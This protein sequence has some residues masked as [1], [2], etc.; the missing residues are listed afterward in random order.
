[1][2]QTASYVNSLSQSVLI[3][4]SIIITGTINAASFTGSL[5]GTASYANLSA[6]ASYVIT[7]Q[8]ASYVQNAQTASYTIGYTTTSSFNTFT[9]SYNT[10]SFT[11]SFTGSLLGTAS[12]ANL[13]ATASYSV[14]ASTAS[15]ASAS[16]TTGFSIG[17]SQIYY[18]NVTN[19]GVTSPFNVFTNSTGSFT[20]AFYNYTIYSGSNAR[21]GSIV[22]AW[23]NG[24]SS[25][26]EYSTLDVVGT[27][28]NVS[29]SASIV[30]GQV[31]LN[32]YNAI[33]GWTIKAT[34]NLI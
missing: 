32:F 27:T 1:L 18:A 21:A 24:T 5:L 28:L 9:G 13:S 19:N 15:Y 30:N 26:T 6:T 22:A 29:A 7:A 8:T 14:N 34:A 23:N 12:Y 3:T 17:G 20:A 4:G 33:N 25:Y 31:Q 16:T 11:G 10:G 2:A